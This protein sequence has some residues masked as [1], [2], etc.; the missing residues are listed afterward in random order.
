MPT[1][2]TIAPGRVLHWAPEWSCSEG[3]VVFDAMSGDFWV[4]DPPHAR[5]VRLLERGDDPESGDC[6][7]IGVEDAWVD[8]GGVEAMIKSGLLI[9][10]AESAV[11]TMKPGRT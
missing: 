4:L 3:R 6:T 11:G 1:G 2:L 8:A 5:L 10:R 9:G 7:L